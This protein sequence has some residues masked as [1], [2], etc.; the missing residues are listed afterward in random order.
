MRQPYPQI[1]H[2]AVN[3]MFE[4]IA[5]PLLPPRQILL[6]AELIIRQSCGSNSPV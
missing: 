5:N 2:A 4:R 1:A 6:K 3:A